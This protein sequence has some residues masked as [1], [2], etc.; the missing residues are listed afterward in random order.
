MFE[1]TYNNILTNLVNAQYHFTNKPKKEAI[2]W[3][4]INL[5]DKAIEIMRTKKESIISH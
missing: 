1:V 5:F 4:L 2:D 3:E